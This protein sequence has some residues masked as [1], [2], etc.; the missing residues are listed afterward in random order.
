MRER[1]RERTSAG[2][3]GPC[4]RRPQPR[5]ERS[6]LRHREGVSVKW[7]LGRG[8]G[9]DAS[10]QARIHQC[11]VAPCGWRPGRKTGKPYARVPMT[12]A[13]RAGAGRGSTRHADE[14]GHG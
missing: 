12:V 4:P 7:H 14:R 8:V 6:P 9:A 5:G 13:G 11:A 2:V 10:R 1:E 3:R